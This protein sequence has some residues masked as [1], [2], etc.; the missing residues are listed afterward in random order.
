MRASSVE[1]A[2]LQ[3]DLQPG[4]LDRLKGSYNEASFFMLLRLASGAEHLDTLQERHTQ[5]LI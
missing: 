1:K 3:L 5:F 2:R 4:F